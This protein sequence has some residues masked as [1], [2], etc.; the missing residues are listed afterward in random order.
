MPPNRGS[1]S[2]RTSQDN[3]APGLR[4]M[5]LPDAALTQAQQVR[6]DED[7]SGFDGVTYLEGERTLSCH[8]PAFGTTIAKIAGGCPA[9]TLRL[10][11]NLLVAHEKARD[12]EFA[13][14]VGREEGRIIDLLSGTSEPMPGEGFSGWIRVPAKQ[15]RFASLYLDSAAQEAGDL[16]VATRMVEAGNHDFAWARFLNL[17]ALVQG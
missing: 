3:D 12:V 2:A 16:Y 10:S 13:L 14:V 11:A 1:F 9:G 8:P 6:L 7:S 5:A 17:H 15:P 4:E